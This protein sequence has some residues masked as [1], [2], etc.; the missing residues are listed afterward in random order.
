MDE[1]SICFAHSRNC[2]PLDNRDLTRM[3]LEGREQADMLWRFIRGHVPGFDKSWLI[4]T[5][6]SWE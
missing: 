1:V 5:A 2:K 3:Y 4:D 6:P